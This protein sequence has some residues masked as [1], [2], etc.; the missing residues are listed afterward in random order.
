MFASYRFIDNLCS[1]QKHPLE[2]LGANLT[3]DDVCQG[4]LW[5]PVVELVGN[6][7][8]LDAD[9]SELFE[10]GNFTK[11]PVIVGRNTDE[12]VSSALGAY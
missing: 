3:N 10:S 11:V 5:R 9:P 6:E 1:F 8:F 2:I 4:K 12:Y 7:R